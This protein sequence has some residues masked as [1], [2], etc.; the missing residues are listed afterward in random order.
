MKMLPLIVDLF[1]LFALAIPTSAKQLRA[2]WQRAPADFSQE[3]TTPCVLNEYGQPAEPCHIEF[4]SR[5]M[6]RKWL[7]SNATVLE[8]GARYGSVS[9]VIAAMQHQSG[10]V[11]CVEPDVTVWDALNTNVKT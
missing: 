11:V 1:F 7:P 5:D 6:V 9:C 8:V 10:K 3:S 4:N 2:S